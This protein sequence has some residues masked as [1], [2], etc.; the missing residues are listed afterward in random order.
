MARTFGQNCANRLR[1]HVSSITVASIVDTG[2]SFNE[3]EGSQRRLSVSAPLR[4][5]IA[6]IALFMAVCVI[7]VVGYVAA[8][9]KLDD[10]IYMVIITLFGVGY[11]EVQPVQSPALRAL[12]IIVIIATP[13][14][15]NW[16]PPDPPLAK[17]QAHESLSACAFR[18]SPL[19]IEHGAGG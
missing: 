16:L 3:Q 8:G 7:A 6:G 18:G 10:S 14:T 17:S 9:W 15:L 13:L 5:M 4:K 2:L 1:C 19:A 11:G 12:T